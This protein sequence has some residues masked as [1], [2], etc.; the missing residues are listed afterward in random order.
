MVLIDFGE[1]KEL[2]VS[3]SCEDIQCAELVSITEGGNMA[4][5]QHLPD[6][7]WRDC[8]QC[9]ALLRHSSSQLGDL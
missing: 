4:C 1:L 2:A 7:D 8:S 5:P 3:V 6:Y 9:R